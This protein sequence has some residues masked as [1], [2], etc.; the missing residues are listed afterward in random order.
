MYNTYG[1]TNPY[2][3]PYNANFNQPLQNN[4]Q[5]SAVNSVINKSTLNGKPVDSI[6]VAKSSD[7]LLDGS[8]NYFPLLDNTAIVTKQL[9]TDG[10][11][12][13]VIFKPIE[14]QKE[15]NQ[16]ITH[17]ELKQALNGF[18]FDEIEDIKEEIKELKQDIK[19][20]KKGDSNE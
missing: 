20:I 14:E 13:I 12:K 11:S 16:Y 15:E 7:Y 19:K 1:Y 2:Y 10:T 9:K 4:M 8:I 17:D 18:N 5:S 3:Q 6:D